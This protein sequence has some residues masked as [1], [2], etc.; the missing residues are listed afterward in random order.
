MKAVNQTIFLY[1][2]REI[3]DTLGEAALF[4]LL[5]GIDLMRLCS[6]SAMP[7]LWQATIHQVQVRLVAPA[8]LHVL[9][10]QSKKLPQL[11]VLNAMYLH[12]P[13]VALN[14]ANQYE[15]TCACS[16]LVVG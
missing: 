8:L 14:L 9:I 11:L 6:R 2:L 7:Q 12:T 10:V 13:A 15:P 4:T 3:E 5:S 1:L 16:R